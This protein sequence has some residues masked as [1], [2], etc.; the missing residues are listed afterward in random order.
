MLGAQLRE[1]APAEMH[2]LIDVLN[3]ASD[4]LRHGLEALRIGKTSS[5]YGG[6]MG[7]VRQAVEKVRDQLRDQCDGIARALY[8][9]SG[10]TRNTGAEEAALELIQSLVDV[11]DGV[12]D[13]CSKPPHGTTRRHGLHFTMYPDAYDAQSALALALSVVSYIVGRLERYTASR[14]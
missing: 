11:L 10:I 2:K 6:V 3:S 5:D 14:R 4:E 8:V 13:L 12:F 9:E 1:K 7:G